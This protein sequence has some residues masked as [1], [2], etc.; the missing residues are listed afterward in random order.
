MI[1]R[2]TNRIELGE[3]TLVALSR[4]GERRWGYHQFPALSRLPD[5]RILLM[6]ADAEDASE[7]HGQPAPAFVSSDGTT[8][9]PFTGEPQPIRPHYSISPVGGGEYLVA[10]ASSYF[11]CARAGV[12]LPEPAAVAEVYGTLLTYRT[13]ELPAAVL[14][15]LGRLPALRFDPG[16]GSWRAE[17]IDYD[18]RGRLAWRREG[19]TLL[20][21]PFFERALLEYRGELLYPDYRVRF[22]T[23]DGRIPKKG[24]T[25]LMV[26]TDRGHSFTRRSLV[27]G[28]L[29]GHDLHG[30]PTLSSTSDGNLVCVVRRTDQVQKPMAITWSRNSGKSWTPSLDLFEFGVFPCLLLLDCGVLLLSF[31]RPGVH[32]AVSSDGTG[33]RWDETHVI[34]EGDRREVSRYSCGYT[35]L[36]ALDERRALIAYSDFEYSDD[37]AQHKA[38]LVRELL[39]SGSGGS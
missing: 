4:P 35:S 23:D 33:R 26:S 31:G 7:S 37:G 13:A 39:V 32:L 8:W 20:P 22:E 10:P 24:C 15:D 27:S 38:I 34:I 11:D 17:R 25:W 12:T 5:G 30:E 18:L 1:G 28:D 19:S 2:R 3:P 6:Y 14:D 16:S 21:R 9:T 36:L 29:S